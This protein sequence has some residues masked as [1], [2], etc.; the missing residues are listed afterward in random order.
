MV[1]TLCMAVLCVCAGQNFKV[2]NVTY[3]RQ[4]AEKHTRMHLHISYTL[5]IVHKDMLING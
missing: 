3:I 4:L 5:Y 1:G 2:C